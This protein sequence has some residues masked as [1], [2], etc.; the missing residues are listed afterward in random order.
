[1][2]SVTEAWTAA[3][4]LVASASRSS[5][6]RQMFLGFQKRRKIMVAMR[7]TTPE[8]MST[9]L[10]SMKLDQ[11]NWVPAKE[12]PTT[13]MAGRTSTVSDQLTMARTSQKGTITAVIGRMRPIMALR[14]LSLRAV[15]EASAW[16]GVPIAPKATGAVLAM[17][18]SA[19]AWK[20]L[21]PRPIMN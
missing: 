16:M 14:S 19:A 6:K 13:R 4:P 7:E 20:G 18:L 11:K 21:K 5:G 12:T 17:R 15:T 9:R 3:A 8:A 10:L 1:M 2:V